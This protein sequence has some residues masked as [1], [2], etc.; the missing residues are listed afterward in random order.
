MTYQKIFDL[1]FK[2]KVPTLKLQETF[3]RESDKIRR[4][5]LMELPLQ[6]LKRLIKDEK[7]V[8]DLLRLKRTL[9]KSNSHS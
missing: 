8:D 4:V 5:A 6:T 3:P 9:A 2:H 1:K 7:K